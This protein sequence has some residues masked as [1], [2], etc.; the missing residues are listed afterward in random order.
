MVMCL[1]DPVTAASAD[2]ILTEHSS[3]RTDQLGLLILS[4][5]VLHDGQINELPRAIENL[6][7]RRLYRF[8]PLLASR[9]LLAGTGFL[10]AFE[11]DQDVDLALVALIPHGHRPKQ[12][13]TWLFQCLELLEHTGQ[14]LFL[15]RLHADLHQLCP[16]TR[17]LPFPIDAILKNTIRMTSVLATCRTARVRTQRQKRRANGDVAILGGPSHLRPRVPSGAQ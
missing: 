7:Q 15:L 3:V 16:H 1:V 17:D 14:I 13:R 4:R 12:T 2:G 9:I 5:L 10:L 6:C 11:D 8:Q